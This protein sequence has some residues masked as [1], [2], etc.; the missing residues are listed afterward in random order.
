MNPKVQEYR[1]YDVMNKDEII[2]DDPAWKDY[3]KTVVK[4][5]DLY[6]KLDTFN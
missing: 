1:C 2:T 6:K 4:Y 3:A 5:E